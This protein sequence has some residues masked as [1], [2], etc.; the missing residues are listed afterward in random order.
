MEMRDPS[1]EP[2]N[3]AEDQSLKQADDAQDVQSTATDKPIEISSDDVADAAEPAVAPAEEAEAE[4][5]ISQAVED[6]EDAESLIDARQLST[7]EQVIEAAKSILARDP[8]DIVREDVS[9]LRQHFGTLQ[10]ADSESELNQWI[11]QGNKP[12]DFQPAESENEAQFKAILAQIKEKKASFIAAQEAERAANLD[13]KNAI[14][15][16]I[17][18]LAGDTDNVNRTFPR[19]RELQDEFNA[20]GDV[21]PT[22]ETKVWKRF[23][24]ARE[25]YSDNLKINKELRDY[26]FKKNQEQK[27]VLIQEAQKLAESNDIITAFKHLQELHIQWRKI[28]PVAKEMREDIWNRFKEISAGINKRYQAFFEERKSREADNEKGK[29][30]ICER[31]EALD[32]SDLATFSA[33]EEMTQKIKEAQEDWKKFGFASRRMNNALFSRFRATCDTFFAAKAAYFKGVK[34]S[35][36]QNLAKK[37]ALAERA[38]ALQ[39]STQWRKTTDEIIELQK[40][41]KT[42]GS[43][44]KRHSDAVWKRFQAAC[45]HFF[46]N[47]NKNAASNTGSRQAEQANLV[48]K[49]ALIARLDEIT[50]DTPKMDAITLISDLQKEWQE[51]GHVPF[52]DKEKVYEAFRGKIN[53]IRRR[54]HLSENHERAQRFEANLAQMEGDENKLYRERE[55]Q[56]RLLE[57]RR[58]ELRTYENNLGFLSAKSKSG[59]NLVQ[60]FERKIERLKEDIAALE[61]K[62]KL[63]DSKID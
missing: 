27:E 7:Q 4:D 8:K 51:I 11:E 17:I 37:I 1:L 24:D 53:E 5:I 31:V 55:R 52:K 3:G 60:D 48:A 39:D 23:Q 35:L 19:Y 45:D 18:S 30:E 15:D 42:I 61:D 47:K 44:A 54:Y 56:A 63:I 43:V 13:K 32:F 21:P 10:K 20:V 28:G 36:A 14:I 62:I 33:W 46:D 49:R 25:Q 6:T 16:E 29:T 38:E 40:E 50:E 34:E 57:T 58:A 41:W 2:I 22:E 9:R 26:D 12:E 59:N